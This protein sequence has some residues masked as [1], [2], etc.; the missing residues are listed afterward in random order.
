MLYAALTNRVQTKKYLSNA[1]H[2]LHK[3]LKTLK[4]ILHIRKDARFSIL[5]LHFFVGTF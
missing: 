3:D 5:L 2:T 4:K 1:A